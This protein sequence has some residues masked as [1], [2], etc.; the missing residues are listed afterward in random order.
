M[1][2]QNEL[3]VPD[4]LQLL[5]LAATALVRLESFATRAR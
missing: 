2:G 5:E 3:K 4:L 1:E